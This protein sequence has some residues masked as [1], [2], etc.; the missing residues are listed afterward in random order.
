MHDEFSIH[1]IDSVFFS[2]L[3]AEKR[4]I[5][6]YCCFI[7]F[8]PR[9]AIANRA[10][11]PQHFVSIL[12]HP[13]SPYLGT[14]CVMRPAGCPLIHFYFILIILLNFAII[15]TQTMIAIAAKPTITLIH[16]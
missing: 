2:A 12:I 14:L 16:H 7:H 10:P 9:F 8:D 1:H 3:R 5:Q 4:K 13:F 11:A 6:Q 15:I